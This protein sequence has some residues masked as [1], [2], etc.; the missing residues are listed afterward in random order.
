MNK[1]TDDKWLGKRNSG[2]TTKTSQ[3][4]ECDICHKPESIVGG[5]LSGRNKS[6]FDY[7]VCKHCIGMMV[8]SYKSLSEVED[9]KKIIKISDTYT[10]E[11]GTKFY[12]LHLGD[13]T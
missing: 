6:G 2:I 12:R 9:Y 11:D 4:W 7:Q 1:T 8:E 13:K 3:D 10:F 5:L